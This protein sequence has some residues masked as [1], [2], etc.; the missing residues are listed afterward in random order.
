MELAEHLR[1]LREVLEHLCQQDVIEPGVVHRDLGE[2]TDVIGLGVR[3]LLDGEEIG[4]LVL[5]MRE[6][7]PVG[8]A[9]GAGVEDELTRFDGTARALDEAVEVDPAA[10][11]PGAVDAHRWQAFAPAS[12]KPPDVSATYSQR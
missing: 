1:G 10:V 5:G 9:P 6:Q 7:T 8:R 11:V 3:L 12:W 2:V 4:R